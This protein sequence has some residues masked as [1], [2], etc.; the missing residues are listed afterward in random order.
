MAAVEV[1]REEVA[2]HA[3][4]MEKV[5]S[6]LVTE[7]GRLRGG[8]GRMGSQVMKRK[9]VS[10]VSDER[11]GDGDDGSESKMKKDGLVPVAARGDGED[12]KSNEAGSQ[13]GDSFTE[14]VSSS[15]DVE[16]EGGVN[17]QVSETETRPIT[18]MGAMNCLRE[19]PVSKRGNGNEES[20]VGMK[21]GEV[22]EVGVKMGE[23]SEVDVRMGAVSKVGGDEE[24]V[25]LGG[26]RG[27][28]VKVDE[29]IGSGESARE[30][31]S[32]K[33]DVVNED[34]DVHDGV[35]H[36]RDLLLSNWGVISGTSLPRPDT[37]DT[38]PSAHSPD[39]ADPATSSTTHHLTH[40]SFLT[41]VSVDGSEEVDE[42]DRFLR[43]A[44]NAGLDEARG[45]YVE[46]VKQLEM[47]LNSAR[48]N[49]C[50]KTHQLTLATARVS[51]MQA[52]EVSLK[53]RVTKTSADLKAAMEE[54]NTTKRS[55]DS[56]IALLSDSFADLSAK[57]A[58]KDASLASI[59]QLKIL[60]GRCGIWN[61]V[62]ALTSTDGLPEGTVSLQYG[63]CSRCRFRVALPP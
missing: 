6:Q 48:S 45:L 1:E 21:M 25:R 59:H 2:R 62:G 19:A 8:S 34:G 28:G 56:Q 43:H 57:I 61:S 17:K 63:S 7:L 9:G 55:Y 26:E 33:G 15:Q 29:G 41:A 22:S 36:V 47:M 60:C 14:F 54:I 24:G 37:D 13:S 32:Q 31:R 50:N 42:V 40:P 18:S 27:E 52:N 3:T 5:N 10:E 35:S 46:S 44:K 16:R 38:P 51:A 58:D 39:S 4:E 23:V 30:G 49:L 11:K 53:E 20:E 12:H